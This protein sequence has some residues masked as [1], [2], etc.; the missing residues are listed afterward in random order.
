MPPRD[1]LKNTLR[2]I[3][4]LVIISVGYVGFSLVSIQF[5]PRFGAQIFWPASG[6]CV[7]ALAYAMGRSGAFKSLG[8]FRFPLFVVPALALT[9][10]LF[11]AVVGIGMGFFHWEPF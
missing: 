10:F 7:I 3:A 4:E 11:F 5:L 2:T 1:V 6:L 9:Y 8:W